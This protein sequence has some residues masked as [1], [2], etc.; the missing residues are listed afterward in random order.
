MLAT[1]TG[2]AKREAA[3]LLCSM[4]RFAEG[5]HLFP[6]RYRKAGPP[7]AAKLPLLTSAIIRSIEGGCSVDPASNNRIRHIVERAGVASASPDSKQCTVMDVL[8]ALF[9]YAV[10]LISSDPQLFEVRWRAC[11]CSLACACASR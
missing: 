8:T 5:Q 1:V 2:A 4:A 6:A 11:C 3:L 9:D 10:P 7:L